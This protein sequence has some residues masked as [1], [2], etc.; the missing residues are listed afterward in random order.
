VDDQ[1]KLA[2]YLAINQAMAKTVGVYIIKL[3]LFYMLL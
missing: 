1:L 2:Y 3:C